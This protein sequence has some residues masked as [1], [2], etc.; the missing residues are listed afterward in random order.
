MLKNV[1]VFFTY[2]VKPAIRSK[3]RSKCCKYFKKIVH[4]ANVCG[5][6]MLDK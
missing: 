1:N 6:M 3:I 4:F 5:I 2:N